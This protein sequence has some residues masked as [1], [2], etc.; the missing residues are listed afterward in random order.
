M[1]TAKTP[2]SKGPAQK[3]SSA[4]P[5]LISPTSAFRQVAGGAASVSPMEFPSL[6]ATAGTAAKPVPA[7]AKKPGTSKRGSEGT[8]ATIGS[9]SRVK[10]VSLLESVFQ[11]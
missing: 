5:A 6:S 1:P 9:V 10:D 8:I 11:S 4:V 7:K 3:P 2:T